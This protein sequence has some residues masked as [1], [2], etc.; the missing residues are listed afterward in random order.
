MPFQ[1]QAQT[2]PGLDLCLSLF[3]APSFHAPARVDR[4]SAR[5]AIA[6]VRTPPPR[7]ASLRISKAPQRTLRQNTVLYGMG[8]HSGGRTGLVLQPLPPGS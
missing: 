1:S 4:L 5:G 6:G 7:L 3:D 8:L 2:C